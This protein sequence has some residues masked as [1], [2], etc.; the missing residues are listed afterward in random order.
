MPPSIATSRLLASCSH[1]VSP[2]LTLALITSTTSAHPA[3]IPV[4]QVWNPS[5]L[6]TNLTYQHLQ[7]SILPEVLKLA[8]S[9]LL[10]GAA[11]A[12]ML[13][14]F[15]SLVSAGS[16]SLPLDLSTSPPGLPGLS[17]SDMLALLVTPVLGARGG[18]IHKQGRAN[19]AKCAASLV[20]HSQQEV[21]P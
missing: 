10:Q 11:L 17:H 6:S 9:P 16:P 15:R 12:A 19:I 14:F 4:V 3:T 18:A 20:S 8:E 2:Q 7:K 1:D 21:G 5:F 13:D